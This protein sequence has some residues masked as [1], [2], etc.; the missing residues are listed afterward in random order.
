MQSD[1]SQKE[2][3]M[4]LSEV[5]SRDVKL[6]TP[7]MSIQEAAGLMRDGNFGVLPVGEN[8]R[9]VGMVTDRDV[10]VRCCAN[11]HDPKATKLKDVMTDEVRWAYEDASTEEAAKIMQKHQIRRMP[12][13]NKDKRLVGIVALGDFAVQSSAVRPAIETL[14]SISRS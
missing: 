9:L 5:M 2:A 4:Q 7:D 1:I 8:D 6:A 3:V 10:T 11:G 13:I 12:V 14:S